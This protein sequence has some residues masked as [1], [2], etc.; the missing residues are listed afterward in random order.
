MPLNPII[1]DCVFKAS[2]A[3]ASSVP[4]AMTDAELGASMSSKNQ[5]T[6]V[7]SGVKSGAL[8]NVPTLHE[9]CIRVLQRNIDG[10]F[11]YNSLVSDMMPRLTL[12]VL[13][14]SSGG[15]WWRTVRNPQAGVGS[16]QSG[17]T[18]H[19]RG[20]QSVSDR[21]HRRHVEVALQP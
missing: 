19:A 16:S 6:K 18:V 2:P 15:N 12:T 5:R 3:P 21:R 4:K 9:M 10:K 7:Y 17:A 14:I 13:S 20:L 8:L 11:V 1:M